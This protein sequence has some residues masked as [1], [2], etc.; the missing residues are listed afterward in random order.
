MTTRD[1]TP[2]IGVFSGVGDDIHDGDDAFCRIIG[3]TRAEFVESRRTLEP[4][5]PPEWAEVD[6]EALAEAA[7]TGGFTTPYRK[8]F[9]RP[10]GTRVP[11]LIV[12]SYLGDASDQWLGYAVDLT[13][14]T[15]RV[16]L[17]HPVKLTDPQPLDFYERLLDAL[18]RDRSLLTAMLDGTNAL[19]YAVDRS[20]RLLAANRAFQEATRR[21]LGVTLKIGAPVLDPEFASRVD[22]GW[23]QWYARAFAG[24]RFDVVLP[25][26]I[27]TVYELEFS[28]L[29]DVDGTIIGAVVVGVDITAEHRADEAAAQAAM[30]QRVAGQ[31][32]G[33]AGWHLE[34]ADETVRLTE[35][36][37]DLIGTPTAGPFSLESALAWYP[38]SIRD[39]VAA[40]TYRCLTDGETFDIEV[41]FDVAELPFA[42]ETHF[43]RETVWL[44]VIGEPVHRDGQVVA[45]NGAVVDISR[46]KSLELRL[47]ELADVLES[48]SEA[49]VIRD[50]GGTVLHWN[51]AAEEMYGWSAAEAIGHHIADLVDDDDL[52]VFHDMT[53][54]LLDQGEWN[55]RIVN[56]DRYGR[57]FPVDLHVELIRD[58]RDQPVRVFSIASDASER[59][60]LES[61]LA[62]AQRLEAVGQLTGG[63]AHDFNNLLTIVIGSVE[64]LAA[65]GDE[66]QVELATMALDAAERGARL[67][68]Q[69]LAFARRQTLQPQVVDPVSTVQSLVHLL[70]RTLP[71]SIEVRVVADPD[72]WSVSVDPQQLDSALM[73][74]GINARDAM[75]SGGQLTFSLTN[76]PRR[77]DRE[78]DTGQDADRDLVAISVSDTGLGMSDTVRE[79]AFDPFFTTKGMA[80]NSG[81]G[82][83]MVYGFSVQSGGHAEISST[84]GVGTTV[85]ILLPRAVSPERSAGADEPLADAP[86]GHEHVLVVEDEPLVRR[87]A[88]SVLRSLG[89][90]VTTASDGRHAL[91][92]LDRIDPV[93]LVFTDLV[94]PGGVD[95]YAL[96]A[97]ILEIAPATR[98][99]FTTGHA[100]S[101]TATRAD[102]SGIPVLA[103]P[104]RRLG[105][106]TAVRAAIDGPAVASTPVAE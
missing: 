23:G 35:D 40:A 47:R 90:T 59:A 14:R 74:L 89:Y 34:A 20:L 1:A 44:R 104:Y 81:L 36:L 86:E 19:I 72:V 28:P 56:R 18:V 85:R 98:I 68:G 15:D 100:G 46:Y 51:A 30:V 9:L 45:V 26:P 53:E 5:S 73:N 39:E 22:S 11:V 57:S 105:I 82:L 10:D 2:L 3:R 27:D 24:E 58:E 52:D 16:P 50:L 17:T 84:P 13:P 62:R 43:G 4:L 60:E 6:R 7:R 87:H 91:E 94:M 97:R 101:V 96:A 70:R 33:V 29:L 93:D 106:A 25:S 66:E 21:D 49:V 102:L 95:G 79:R 55:G 54:L 64:L 92:L 41:R 67:T 103:K 32:G 42:Q 99:L 12:F 61:R 8:E 76:L 83:S 75:P 71:E 80:S 69:L 31:L 38:S 78:S 77:H 65:T 48:S 88:A 37:A 63:I